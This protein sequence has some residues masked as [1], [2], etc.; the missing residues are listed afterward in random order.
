[1]LLRSTA[2]LVVG[3]TVVLSLTSLVLAWAA[4]VPPPSPPIPRPAD[5]PPLDCLP[6]RLVTGAGM[7]NSQCFDAAHDAC[8]VTPGC[9]LVPRTMEL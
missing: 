1:M 5:P 8:Q 2:L 9:A 7:T 4:H 6:N 3:A